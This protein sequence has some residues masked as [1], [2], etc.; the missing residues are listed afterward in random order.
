MFPLMLPTKTA[1]GVSVSA[2]M[3]RIIYLKEDFAMQSV[4]KMKQKAASNKKKTIPTGEY[5]ST[6]DKVVWNDE[7]K[8]NQVFDIH[9]TL[10]DKDGKKYAHWERFFNKR[11][12]TRTQAFLDYLDD[13]NIEEI[14][15]FEGC[16]E[17]VTVK[18]DVGKYKT[19]PSIDDRVLISKP[20][21]SPVI[22]ESDGLES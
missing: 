13:N 11:G 20:A 21:S 9:Y 22:T 14:E 6:V 3:Q 18:K 5:T 15:D 7:Y 19:L 10:E 12:N 1:Y 2:E 4:K 17:R 8:A 16:V